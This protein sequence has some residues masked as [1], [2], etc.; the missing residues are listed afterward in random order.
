M[1]PLSQ[2]CR[3]VQYRP[4]NARGEGRLRH[5]RRVLNGFGM[6]TVEWTLYADPQLEGLVPHVIAEADHTVAVVCPLLCFAIIE[7]H[8]VDQAVWQ[9]GGLQHIPTRP[10]DIDSLHGMDGQFGRS[11]WFPHLLGGWHDLWDHRANHRLHIHN[12]IDLRPSLPYMT[13]YIQ[14]VHTE[15]FSQGDQHLVPAGVVPEDLPL[16]HPLAL[17]LHQPKDGHLPELRLP[18]GRGRGRGRGRARGRGRRGGGGGREQGDELH[19]DRDPVNP[20]VVGQR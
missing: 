6:F 10:L 15:L 4:D 9:F 16:H 18:A 3:W 12:H 17:E 19:R 1:L 7:W 20:Q 13:W 2:N 8:H 5:Y 11:E 14:W